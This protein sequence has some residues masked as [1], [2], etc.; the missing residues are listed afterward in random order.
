MTLIIRN[1]FRLFVLIAL[2]ILSTSNFALA[3]VG[4][5]RGYHSQ[6]LAAASSNG[7]LCQLADR[8]ERAKSTLEQKGIRAI[9]IAD[10]RAPRLMKVTHW[11]LYK[12]R[13]QNYDPRRAYD[14]PWQPAFSVWKGWTLAAN[15]VDQRALGILEQINGGNFRSIDISANTL[16]DLHY[17]TL[18]LAEP[19]VAGRWRVGLGISRAFDKVFAPTLQEIQR[20]ITYGF[21]SARMQGN[22]L[23]WRNTACVEDLPEELQKKIPKGREFELDLK[24]LPH[25]GGAFVDSQGVQR[26]CGYFVYADDR[27]IQDQ[28][29]R[30]NADVNRRLGAFVNYDR[31]PQNDPLLIAAR[32]QRWIVSLHPFIGGNGRTS[33]LIM[34]MILQ[35]V[36]LPAPIISDVDFD[37]TSSDEQWAVELARGAEKAIGLLESCARN[38]YVAQ[39]FVVPEN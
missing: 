14:Q 22:I 34:D 20:G 23:R 11:E 35:G 1:Q 2:T 8:Y 16:V 37:I 3:C 29:K 15:T 26:Q 13:F 5:L 39:C 19:R 21:P 9:H 7:D 17:K 32:A 33:R 4:A 30:V 38:P 31:G 28:I 27:E 36:G 12:S 10:V 18:S 6:F 25:E 24:Y